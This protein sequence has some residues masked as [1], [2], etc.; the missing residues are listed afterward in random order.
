MSIFLEKLAI[1]MTIMK[2]KKDYR[3]QLPLADMHVNGVRFDPEILQAHKNQKAGATNSK[4]Y[5]RESN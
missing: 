5:S 3:S 1:K 2:K 4:E